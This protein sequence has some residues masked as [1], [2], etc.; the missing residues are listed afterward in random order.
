M[1]LRLMASP[2]TAVWSLSVPAICFFVSRTRVFVLWLL[3][4]YSCT[5]VCSRHNSIL[6]LCL[7]CKWTLLWTH[8]THLVNHV[9]SFQIRNLWRWIHSVQWLCHL[10]APE[11]LMQMGIIYPCFGSG[12]G[13]PENLCCV[14]S[15]NGLLRPLQDSPPTQLRPVIK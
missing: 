9:N 11:H 12:W 15:G 1:T 8:D 6:S 14:V 3:H 5:Q 7:S 10:D 13:M 4:W 2:Q